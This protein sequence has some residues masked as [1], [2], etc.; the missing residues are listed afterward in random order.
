MEVW[1]PLLI[2]LAGAVIREALFARPPNITYSIDEETCN[3]HVRWLPAEPPSSNCTQQYKVGMRINGSWNG[4]TFLVHKET[5]W[6]EA[7][8]VGEKVDFGV[9]TTCDSNDIETADWNDDETFHVVQNGTAGTGAKNINCIWWNKK[10]MECSWNSGGK[11]SSDTSY[12]L[13]YWEDGQNKAKQ[14]R[15]VTRKESEFRCRF[16][17]DFHHLARIHISVQGKSANIQTTCFITESVNSLVKFDPPSFTDHSKNRNEMFLQ[18]N[19]PVGFSDSCC[20]S[21]VEVN[22]SKSEI[23]HFKHTY[24]TTIP[25]E[26]NVQHSFRVRIQSEKGHWSDW[27]DVLFDSSPPS[28]TSTY[29]WLILIPLCVALLLVILLIYLK[30][31]KLL[32]FPKIPDPGKIL[33]DVFE[34]QIENQPAH[35]TVNNDETHSLMLVEPAGNEK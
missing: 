22:S 13:S 21:E 33:K 9:K 35:E 24:S 12:K 17:L 19:K 34:E 27:S 8:P 5:F 26:P 31:I 2:A 15:N 11:A 6:T 16:D 7:V 32:I 4:L 3:L 29:L 25:L 30:R 28:T 10:S 23:K 18:W 1:V 14:C 20:D